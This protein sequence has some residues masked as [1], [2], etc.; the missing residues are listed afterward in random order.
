MF[1]FISMVVYFLRELIFDKKDEFDLKS[2][3][4]NSR[5]FTV[6]LILLLSLLL[7]VFMMIRVYSLAKHQLDIQGQLVQQS[8]KNKETV[9]SDSEKI[10]YELK[11]ETDTLSSNQ[12]T[13]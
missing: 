7:N 4:F 9:P 2:S 8:A 12:N 11:F 13:N 5:K 6:F 10:H 1:K 3:K